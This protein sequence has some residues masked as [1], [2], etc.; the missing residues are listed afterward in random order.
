MSFHFWTHVSFARIL[1]IRAI[2][3]M[4]NK[5]E[6]S[7]ARHRLVLLRRI[8]SIISGDRKCF[9]RLHEWFREGKLKRNP[10]LWFSAEEFEIFMTPQ[11]Q[12]RWIEW[13]SET[14]LVRERSVVSEGHSRQ[15]FK[16]GLDFHYLLLYNFAWQRDP[17]LEGESLKVT[18]FPWKEP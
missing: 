13:K 18:L 12:S 17:S 7:I 1:I 16:R 9:A 6:M 11:R 2:I 8:K 15:G 10:S 4:V 5:T 14:G 3:F